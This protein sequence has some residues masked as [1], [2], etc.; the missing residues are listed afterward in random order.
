MSV[1]DSAAEQ[2]EA[3]AKESV[4]LRGRFRFLCGTIPHDPCLNLVASGV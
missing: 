1:R 2:A 3:P 4:V